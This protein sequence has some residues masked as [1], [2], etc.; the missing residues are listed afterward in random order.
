MC[1]FNSMED[2]HFFQ[3][4]AGEQVTAELKTGVIVLSVVG[5]AFLALYFLYDHLMLKKAQKEAAAGAQ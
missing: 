2:A 3:V 4:K 5:P 1:Q